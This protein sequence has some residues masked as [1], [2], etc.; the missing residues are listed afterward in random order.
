M[1]DEGIRG[2]RK[3]GAIDL[4]IF[5][6]RQADGGFFFLAH[7]DPNI[8]VEDGGGGSGGWQVLGDEDW[9]IEGI[10]KVLSGHIFFRGGDAHFE[11]E[12]FCRPHPRASDIAIAV[13]DEAN[14]EIVEG[15]AFFLDGLEV[16]ENLA[17]V[18]LV[19]ESVDGGD[20]AEVSKIDDIL[21]GEGADDRAVNH[22]T[23]DAGGIA[24]RF[25][26]TE[27]D[28]V[29]RE[30]HDIAAQLADADFEADSCARGG[31]RKNESPDLG[32]EGADRVMAPLLFQGG[33]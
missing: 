4:V 1:H 20:V 17:G 2:V 27:L 12:F 9:V 31:L 26:A 7:A 18:F 19:G 8:R 33:G 24:D 6:V 29:C 10:E 32:F 21:L 14:G 13:A 11:A 28:I 30:E 5:E 3:E 25:A 23:Q 15:T 22:T 16:G